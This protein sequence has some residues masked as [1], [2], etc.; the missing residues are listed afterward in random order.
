MMRIRRIAK[1]CMACVRSANTN[2]DIV[3]GR[4]IRRDMALSF[5]PVLTSDQHIH[6][7]LVCTSE[8]AEMARCSNKHILRGAAI[9]LNHDVSDSGKGFNLR[10]GWV[11]PHI[12]VTRQLTNLGA[13]AL[14]AGFENAL[15]RRQVEMY[16]ARAECLTNCCDLL[17]DPD[18]VDDHK[19]IG[20][21]SW[22]YLRKG[23]A[24]PT[25]TGSPIQEFAGSLERTPL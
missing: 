23:L 17:L 10:F 25:T 20:R 1:N 9:R 11:L 16:D 7:R 22:G 3:F 12:A 8:I 18:R 19:T 2:Q 6:E 14:V 21:K 15:G 4:Q 24:Y 13:A 5:A